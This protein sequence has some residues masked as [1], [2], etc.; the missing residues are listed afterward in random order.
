MQYGLSEEQEMIA[1]FENHEGPA[2]S[3]V[4]EKL[5]GRLSYGKLRLFLAF[6]T[7]EKTTSNES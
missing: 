7:Q 4:F 6:R 2:L 3:P 1:A 5:G